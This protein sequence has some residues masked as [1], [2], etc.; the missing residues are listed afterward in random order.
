MWTKG[1][2]SGVSIDT[3]D[4]H[5]IDISIYNSVDISINPRST[6]DPIDS[7]S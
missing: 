1:D 3:L 6:H 4:Q 2:R 5:S 7:W